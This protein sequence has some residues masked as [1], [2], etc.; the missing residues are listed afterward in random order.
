MD[1]LVATV[2]LAILFIGTHVGLATEPVRPRLVA[3]LG[4]WGFRGLFFAI[5][6]AAF[7]W[8]VVVYADHRTAGPPGPGLGASTPWRAILSALA[9]VGVTLMVASLAGYPATPYADD[10]PSR[11]RPPRGLERVTR[12][13]FFVGTALFAMS[14]ALLAAHAIGAVLMGALA[15]LAMAGPIHQDAKLRRLRGPAF[16]GY[17]RATSTV[18]FAAI[19][20]GRQRLVLRELPLGALAAGLAVAVGLRAMHAE[21][22]ADRG[23]W[24]VLV[25]V[26]GAAFFTAL[27]WLR[28]RRNPARLGGAARHG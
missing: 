28:D 23:L 16:D 11:I 18:P 4:E 17:V 14:H 10:H 12:H 20:A 6:A 22:F 9:V 24:V 25:V 7:T 8:L 1:P 19:L 27:A 3:A 15:L 26:G 13:P 2:L 21:I 5:A